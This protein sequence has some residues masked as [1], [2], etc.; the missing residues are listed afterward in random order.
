MKIENVITHIVLIHPRTVWIAIASEEASF[1]MKPQ[2]VKNVT[3]Q[4]FYRIVLI[5]R[6]VIFYKI[7][8]PAKTVLCAVT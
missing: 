5:A 1:V 4:P 3:T 6:I 8:S 2:I 7:A